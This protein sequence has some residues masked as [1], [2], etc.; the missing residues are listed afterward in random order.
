[1]GVK[2]FGIR[3]EHRPVPQ[4]LLLINSESWS[5]LPHPTFAMRLMP[6]DAGKETDTRCAGSGQPF[7]PLSC[8]IGESRKAS[9]S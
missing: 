6:I 2:C 4:K 3:V 1:M 8:V 5:P 9:M 7:W